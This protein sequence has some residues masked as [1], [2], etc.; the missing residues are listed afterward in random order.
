MARLLTPEGGDAEFV[1]ATSGSS[2]KSAHG[3]V[4]LVYSDAAG[5]V[6]ADIATYNPAQPNTPG[7]TI[8]G[9]RLVVDANSELPRFWLP[10]E[11][12]TVYV[13]VNG[14]PL[15]AVHA[16]LNARVTALE[17]GIP[18]D[19]SLMH[20]AGPE[21]VTGVKTFNVSPVVPAPTV[22][23]QAAT[24]QYADDRQAAAQTYADVTVA[25]EAVSRSAGDAAL[26]AA[27][28]GKADLD[29]V[30]G[31]LLAS[32]MPAIQ[33]SNFLGVVADQTAM[34][35]LVASKGD[36]CIRSDVEQ[37]FY[38]VGDDP[39]VL[40]NW[41]GLATGSLQAAN[42]LSDVASAAAARTNLGLGTGA[43]KDAP[44][45]GDATAGQ[46][47][48]GSDSRL[49]NDR[50]P[51]TH[52]TSHGPG[53]TDV[54]SG[55]TSAVFASGSVDG[56]SGTASLRTLGTGAQ[57][58]ASGSDSRIVNA[59]QR[60]AQVWNV[61]DHGV[62]GDGTTNDTAAINALITTVSNAGG[63]TIVFPR[64]TGSYII[65]ASTSPGGSVAMIALKNNVT[66]RGLGG[67]IKIK[68]NTCTDAT[69]SYYPI[70]AP[71][72]SNVRV[73]DLIVDGNSANNPLAAV[74]DIVTLI[75]C[76]NS[77]VRGCYF[78]NC[79]DSGV[80]LSDCTNS[81]LLDNRISGA[82]DLCF[83]INDTNV[84]TIGVGNTIS[85]NHL[86]GAP[87]GGI[88]VKRGA[89]RMIISDNWI[90]GCGNGITLESGV[91]NV[92]GQNL[93]I[94]NNRIQ[95]IGYVGSTS[96]VGIA[97]SGCDDVICVN[98][99]LEDIY[100][101]AIAISGARHCVIANN[102]ITFIGTSHSSA[103][104][105]VVQDITG[106][107]TQAASNNIVQGNVI[108][109]APAQGIQVT[110]SGS[111]TKSTNNTV[112][113]NHVVAAG[114]VGIEVDVNVAGLR[115]VGNTAAGATADGSVSSSAT[116]VINA[117]NVAVNGTGTLIPLGST[118]MRTLLVNAG[119]F[120][121]GITPLNLNLGTFNAGLMTSG[122]NSTPGDIRVTGAAGASRHFRFLTAGIERWRLD[123]SV[124]AE[125][126]AN[127]GT[128]FQILA[129]T[130]AGAL[131][132]TDLTINR[133]TGQWAVG[134][135]L[136][137]AGVATGSR[138]ASANTGSMMYDTTIKA[139]I[140][141][142]GAAWQVVGASSITPVVAQS[143]SGLWT[144]VGAGAPATSTLGGG[145]LRLAPFW[146]STQQTLT[147]MA[148]NL[149]A[150]TTATAGT[151]WL[152]L[153]YSDDGTVYPGV[154]FLNAGSAAA[155]TGAST[156]TVSSL[157]TVMPVGLYWVGGVQQNTGGTLATVTTSPAAFVQLGAPSA[158][159]AAAMVAGYAQTSVTGTPP[160]TFTSTVTV[161]NSVPRTMLKFA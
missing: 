30:T 96:F 118:D 92:F 97:L 126:G 2:I 128:N 117:F 160:G 103:I 153:I 109:A 111:G 34:L 16:D 72:L 136:G 75:G 80:M 55:L 113:F 86:S 50:T 49:T 95:N 85:R 148:I 124:D 23:A 22:G 99:S 65:T 70:Y 159:T 31:R 88:G 46:V 134:G 93:S 33:T 51:T 100:K 84:G 66:L 52:A 116:G 62:V 58:A 45:S 132:R 107:L 8:A 71:T 147:D 27:L 25:T 104:G 120:T 48:L 43:T 91:A 90:R 74:A 64:S 13:T 37:T 155:D 60:D 122:N 18:A 94:V 7:A 10:D 35:A 106:G 154:L 140:Q 69:I 105:I 121:S 61:K 15:T 130:D 138:P 54:L 102:Q 81:A 40:G 145:T 36:W 56:T 142:D 129:Y 152:F 158:A 112:A 108:T 63:G 131:L 77:E 19:A 17:A 32:Q 9:S 67:T 114:T 53:G 57:Q 79:V 143:R 1:F 150:A 20:L 11:A 151:T 73:V 26:T 82:R 146:V 119:M 110:A 101:N 135:P 125:S 139:P 144:P 12:T 39:T 137:L 83:Y 24:K 115:L 42:N 44:A 47:V 141:W 89:R 3:L 38:L 156:P 149:T 14:G 123:G 6:L 5:T 4:A 127:A 68:D 157:N 29:G 59:V 41:V 87:S 76:D 78:Y 21:T 28:T 98:N 161:S 133:A